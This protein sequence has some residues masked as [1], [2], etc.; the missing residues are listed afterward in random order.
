MNCFS[1]FR[2][3]FFITG[4]AV[5]ADFSKYTDQE[6]IDGLRKRKSL[7]KQLN[8]VISA[9]IENNFKEHNITLNCPHCSSSKYVS[10]GQ[11]HMFRPNEY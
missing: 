11:K 2:C 6:I 10:N 3:L 8:T 5:N 7:P 4:G 1:S 9:S